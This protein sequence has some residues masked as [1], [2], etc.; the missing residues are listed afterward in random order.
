MSNNTGKA[1]Q[2]LSIRSWPR[3]II[4]VDMDAFFASCEQAINPKLK[5]RPVATGK[6]RGI[7]SA[8][9]YEAKARGVTRA[10]RLFEAR[11][12]CPGLV[13]L[14]SDYETYSLFSIRLF[15]IL[16][17]FSP[18]VEEYS[19]DEAFVDL[20]GL[21]RYHHASY[22]EIANRMKDKVARELGLTV[23][24]GVSI[25]KVLAKIASKHKK[26]NGLTV[27]PGKDIHTYLEALPVGKVWGIGANTAAF[28]KKLGIYTALEYARKD[29]RFIKRR[30]SKPYVEVWHELNG[31]SVYPV[32]QGVVKNTYKSISKVK[33]FTPPLSDKAFVYAQLSKNLENACIKARRYKLAAVKL[34]VMLRNQGFKDIGVE[35]KLSRPSAYP[36][37]LFDFLRSGFTRVYDPKVQYR[38]TGV[39][40]CGLVFAESVQYDL[41]DDVLKLEKISNLYAA[42]DE[43]AKRYGKHSVCHA[44]SLPVKMHL[45]H[46]GERGDVA[47]RKGELFKGEN[48]RQRLGLPMLR[49]KV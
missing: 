45:Q 39:V 34:I 32:A 43:I 12:V 47:M 21:R 8:A 22:S 42:V 49:V 18:D 48:T 44:S 27:I 41:F 29:E 35:L 7:V 9:S 38:S 40:L 46:E 13:I 6:E 36:A 16:R 33:T 15:D 2:P 3:A 24:V 10:M 28:L 5:G 14:P 30:L 26:P 19:I 1:E 11:K 17:S 20:T 37:E 4:H 25:T 23:S 31:R